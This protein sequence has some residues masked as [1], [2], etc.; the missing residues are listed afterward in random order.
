MNSFRFV[1][2]IL[3]V[4]L[5][6][7]S[8]LA[9]D[10]HNCEDCTNKCG[11]SIL[12]NNHATKEQLLR[13]IRL[14]AS[15][16][17]LL[18]HKFA[19]SPTNIFKI[20]YDTSGV[21][22]PNLTDLNQNGIPDF[23][24]SVAY[25]FDFVYDIYINE[26]G[27]R[28][29]YPDNNQRGSDHYDVYLGDVGNSD[30]ANVQLYSEGGTYGFTD[31]TS[32]DVI[33]TSPFMRMYSYIVID[34][35]FAVTDSVR[36][37][38]SKPYAAFKYPGI[39]SLK[40]TVAH[41][42][43]H[44]IQF[45]YGISQPAASTIME[46]TAT[47]VER[48]F[49]ADVPD[50]IKYVRRLFNNPSSMPFGMDDAY[51]GYS[52]SV[53]NQFLIE[54]YGIEI[55]RLLWENVAQGIEVYKALDNALIFYGS[56]LPNSWCEFLEWAYF[57]GDRSG[58]KSNFSNS[59][60]LPTIIPFSDILFEAPSKS[61]SGRLSP[62]EFRL[63]RM[64]FP[65]IGEISDDTLDVMLGNID[66][67]N[68]SKQLDVSRSYFWQVA[69]SEFTN[70]KIIEG[71]NYWY[72][73]ETDT[74]FLCSFR[75]LSKGGANYEIDYAYPSPFRLS[76]DSYILFPAPSDTELYKKV[77]LVLYNSDMTPIYNGIIQVTSNNNKLVVRLD[78][79]PK[80]LT[81]GVYIF[82]VHNGDKIKLGKLAVINE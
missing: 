67:A 10:D 58:D 55:L 18:G 59:E 80:N 50:Y 13:T 39:P 70:S 31:Y 2:G 5:L 79:L 42:F 4:F 12:L 3:V 63:L 60:E 25:Y 23:V 20:H 77:S 51:T 1:T 72:F 8:T 40:V 33:A 56:S 32:K 19:V 45:M 37:L 54:K 66:I 69:N 43:Y 62:I 38:K 75:N 48:Y 44:A 78:D 74:N 30:D 15:G 22:A 82:G 34:N 71:T 9:A 21:H 11:T 7:I 46:M 36:P 16:L 76:Q 73:L 14:D 53:Y 49:F 52:H 29:P 27:Y 64:A 41:E 6:I 28:S 17:P 35:D 65:G 57:T 81:S 61:L 68:A 47:A 24:D 26:L